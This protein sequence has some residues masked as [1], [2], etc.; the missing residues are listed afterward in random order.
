MIIQINVVIVVF[1][2]DVI[3]VAMCTRIYNHSVAG[4]F[5]QKANYVMGIVGQAFQRAG[6]NFQNFYGVGKFTKSTRES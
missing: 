2:D 5:H 3:P 6:Y 4:S 1:V